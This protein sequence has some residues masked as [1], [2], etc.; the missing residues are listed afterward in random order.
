MI[1]PARLEVFV[2]GRP[3]FDRSTLKNRAITMSFEQFLS[4][5]GHQMQVGNHL[6]PK[7]ED[8]AAAREYDQKG[9]VGGD[10]EREKE[11]FLTAGK[12]QVLAMGHGQ[13]TA[14]K[15]ADEVDES[16]EF[17]LTSGKGREDELRVGIAA[18]QE[19]QTNTN[20][21]KPPILDGLARKQLL[22]SGLRRASLGSE[23]N[24]N[25]DDL[26]STTPPNEGIYHNVDGRAVLHS[27]FTPVLGNVDD[28]IF[29]PGRMQPVHLTP[30]DEPNDLSTLGSVDDAQSH[31]SE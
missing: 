1:E 9:L 2:S 25:F 10:V 30:Q 22:E 6:G 13:F 14:R 11:A 23:P 24:S 16:L 5:S 12:N 17:A 20:N 8:S 26:T 18:E 27:G 21:E 29:L 7:R 3:G 19:S 15:M 28:N 4:S 31:T